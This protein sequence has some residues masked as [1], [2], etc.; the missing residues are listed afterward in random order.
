MANQYGFSLGEVYRD[1]ESIKGARQTNEL[2]QMKLDEAKAAPARNALLTDARIQASTGDVAAQ[3]QLLALDPE[4]GP[5]FIEALSGMNAQQREAA[6]RK[7]DE[8]GKMAFYVK[9]GATPEE[10]QARYQRIL[11]EADPEMRQRMPQQYDP[12]EI[13]LALLRATAMD[14]LMENPESLRV[15]DQDVVYKQGME[16]DRGTRTQA[17]GANGGRS[18]KSGDENLIYKQMVELEGG[19]FDAN[20]NVQGL[21]SESQMRAQ[22]RTAEATNLLRQNPQMSLSEAVAETA[23]RS[24]LPLPSLQQMGASSAPNDPANIRNFFIPQ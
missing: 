17:Q 23:R 9:Q 12:K 19:I 8:I 16:V 2:N 3:K 6:Q 5:K 4:N 14:K 15:G 13:E 22:A 21:T 20:G 24:G 18:L 11:Q 1:I 10:K 7:V